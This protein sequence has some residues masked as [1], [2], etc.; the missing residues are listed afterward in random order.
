MTAM[1]LIQTVTVGSAG[2]AAIDFTS[3][4]ATFT[5]LY[6]ALSIRSSAGGAVDFM[7][8]EFNNDTTASN[9]TARTL[10]GSGSGNASGFNISPGNFTADFNASTST[11]STFS[12][13]AAYIPNYRSSSAK[14]R[15]VDHVSENNATTAYQMLVAGLWSGTA[16]ITSIKFSLGGAN[17]VEHTSASLYGILAGSSGGVVVS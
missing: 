1:T 17:F 8:M 3:I 11:A 4:P 6:V 7:K 2:Q 14:H 5:D 9:Y 13:F 15:S 16:A 12:S 10:Y